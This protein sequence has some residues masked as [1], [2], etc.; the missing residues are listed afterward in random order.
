MGSSKKKSTVG[1]KYFT[2]LHFAICH[3][4]V[5]AIRS[6]WWSDKV[7]WSGNV[8]AGADG[9]VMWNFSNEGMFGGDDSEGG[10]S[11]RLEAGFGS[12]DQTMHGVL[13]NG[14]YDPAQMTKAV[15]GGRQPGIPVDGD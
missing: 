2:T 4:T 10:A 12:A 14:A 8:T 15:L 11:G 13:P 1:Y 9:T 5:D 6:V 7:A 3:G